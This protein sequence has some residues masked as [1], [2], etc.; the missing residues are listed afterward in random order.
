MPAKSGSTGGAPFNLDTLRELVE[1]MEQHD[2]TEINLKRGEERWKLRRGP[3]DVLQM[4]PAAGPSPDPVAPQTTAA[5]EPAAQTDD[6]TIEIT[7]PTVGT[8][9][10]APSPDDPPFVKVGTRVQSDTIV[11]LVEAM[12]VFNQIPAEVSGTITDVLVQNADPVEFGQAL[13]KVRPG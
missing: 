10:A 2:L 9:Y 13:F 6:G 8:F 5:A 4:V 3:R 11:C 12:K 7:S 1:M